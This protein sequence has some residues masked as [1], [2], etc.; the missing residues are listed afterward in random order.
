MILQTRLSDA[1]AA[2]YGADLVIVATGSHWAPDGLNGIT[3]TPING[4]DASLADVL[5]PEQ[6]MVDGKRPPGRRVAVYDTE[7]YFTGVGIA[8]FL[9]LEGFETTLVTSFGVVS[10]YSDYTLEGP[11]LRRVADAYGVRARATRSSTRSPRP[12]GRARPTSESASARRRALSSS[13]PSGSA[14]TRSTT[15]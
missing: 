3:H 6:I 14:T 11:Q 2:S 7:G 8:Q 9:A 1:D 10:P 13:S 12:A 5:T 15:P 4:A